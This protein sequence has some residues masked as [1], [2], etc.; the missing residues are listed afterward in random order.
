M[1]QNPSRPA[2]KT[3]NM[4]Q[5]LPTVPLALSLL[6]DVLRMAK[7]EGYAAIKLIHGYGSSGTGGALR[8][9]LQND[10]ARRAAAGEIAALIEG[11]Q[12][13]ISNEAAWA[14]LQ[15]FPACKQDRDLGR[16]NKGISVVVL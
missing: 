9:A 16:G 2:I 8:I 6:N 13:R 15:R 10:L 11:E 5:S 12:W 3:V 4:E 14:L 7:A 1:A